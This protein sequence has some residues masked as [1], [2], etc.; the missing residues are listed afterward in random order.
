MRRSDAGQTWAFE[1]CRSQS[2]KNTKQCW[3]F[4]SPFKILSRRKERQM[5]RRRETVSLQCGWHFYIPVDNRAGRLQSVRLKKTCSTINHQ[6]DPVVIWRVL[7]SGT[8]RQVPHKPSQHIHTVDYIL[9]YIYSLWLN[10][11]Q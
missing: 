7:P 6:L 8:A 2:I 10:Y 11:N 4:T 1:S 5:K 3:T 9:Q